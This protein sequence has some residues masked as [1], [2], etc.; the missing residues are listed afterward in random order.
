M[1]TII[2]L[3]GVHNCKKTTTF[4]RLS[5]QLKHRKDILFLKEVPLMLY[6]LGLGINNDNASLLQTRQK[7]AYTITSFLETELLDSSTYNYVI[8]DRCSLD[9]LVY[10]QYLLKQIPGAKQLERYKNNPKF[11]IY[12]FG[13]KEWYKDVR[14]GAMDHLSG[15]E[16]EE[17]F[18]QYNYL[19]N[20]IASTESFL[21][22]IT[23]MVGERSNSVVGSTYP[24]SL[25]LTK[26]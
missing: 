23:H 24:L 20:D 15:L 19:Y 26:E 4:E 22:E 2:S 13:M 8:T 6:A 5:K 21:A 11:K 18:K 1:T 10:S 9:I 17:I 25:T 3:T 7:L 14:T 16:I 12:Y